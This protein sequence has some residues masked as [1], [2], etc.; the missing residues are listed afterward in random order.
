MNARRTLRLIGL[1][2]SG[3][4]GKATKKYL[5]RIANKATRRT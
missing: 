3:C 1:R 5:K 2:T 4:W